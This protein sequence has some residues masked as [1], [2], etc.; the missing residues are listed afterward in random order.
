MKLNRIEAVL[1]NKGIS[2]TCDITTVVKCVV[3]PQK[4]ELQ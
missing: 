4:G 1:E 2:Q 3:E